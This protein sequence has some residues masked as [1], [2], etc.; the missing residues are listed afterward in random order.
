M[1]KGNVKIYEQAH[2]CMF[3]LARK[4][5]KLYLTKAL[6]A[7]EQEVLRSIG[8]DGWA[9]KDR[10]EAYYGE[11]LPYW[12]KFGIRPKR[13]WFELYGSRD[14]RMD[15]RFLPA[16]LYFNEILPYMNAGLQATGLMNKAYTDYLFSDV[17][18]PRIVVMRIDGTYCD[19]KRNLIREEEAIGLCLERDTDLFVKV[20]V[21]SSGG[22]GIFVLTP[23]ECTHDDVRRI[24][25]EAGASFV[26]QER[27]RQHPL[28]ESLN[29][30]SVST[31]RVLSLLLDDQ[32][33]IESAALRI[34]APGTSHV[35]IHDGGITTEILPGG[36]LHTRVYSDL[37]RW[38]D[39]GKGI[40]DEGFAIPG[41]D[42]VYEEVKRIH[43]RM[44]H[45][46]CIGWDFAV[47]AEGDPVLIEF[48]VFPA[49]GSTQITRCK[50]VF[51]D[52]TDWILEDY[53]RRRTWEKNHRQD[54]LIQ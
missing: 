16:D 8:P 10:Q 25:R 50:P 11:V 5:K 12:K 18:R 24:F 6:E 35:K 22:R 1:T 13:F 19:E 41:M 34:S 47:D 21:D 17:G 45:F 46:R 14:H 4:T 9:L 44:G 49:L 28:L 37:G 26:V 31:I 2:S 20:S 40:F 43:P 15:P 32:V 48:N 27:I 3:S 52:K 36:K 30:S 51:N 39:H 29:P 42:K 38:F 54:V 7:E 23:S 33:Y 53:F